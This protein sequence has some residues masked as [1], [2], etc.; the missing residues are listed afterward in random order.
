MP[1]LIH[2]TILLLT[3]GGLNLRAQDVAPW[4]GT[5][6]RVP[7]LEEYQRNGA[8]FPRSNE[9]LFV[10]LKVH[11]VGRDDGEGYANVDD[12]L[13]ALCIL[14]EDFAQVN[15]EFYLVGGFNFINNTSYYRHN[16]SV[17]RVMMSKNNAPNAIN[18]YVVDDPNGVAG[19]SNYQQ[20]IALSRVEMATDERVWA[21]EI[22]H[23]LSLPHTFLG[24]ENYSHDYAKPAPAQVN[25]VTVEKANGS[26]CKDAGDGFC[27][28]PADY[29][30]DRWTCN[31]DGKSPR[32]QFDPDSTQLRSDGTL[33]MS[34]ANSECQSRFS[35]EQIGAMRANLNS[36]R[37]N[38]IS[39]QPAVDP[40][41]LSDVAPVLLSPRNRETLPFSNQLALTWEA[42]PEAEFY[43]VQ[44]SITPL[45]TLMI[46][47]FIT[48]DPALFATSV[49]L[50]ANR[51]YYWRV[52]GLSRQHYCRGSWSD[53]FQFR[54]GTLTATQDPELDAGVTVFPNP[55]H[56]GEL[57]LRVGQQEA[58]QALQWQL[59]DQMG[60]MVRRGEER[61]GGLTERRVDVR[62]LP[63]GLYYLRL[64]IADRQLTRKIIIGD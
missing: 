25:S 52:R 35:G 37:R 23:Y 51:P 14:N 53:A 7:W 19:Y 56:T 42:V 9:T 63:T 8:V 33:I 38:L 60:R 13:E 46:D 59:I 6:E 47:Q 54:T 22:G 64:Q 30:S 21:H 40:T 36:E 31:S 5:N 57:V 61:L 24:W 3:V 55:V 15:V 28:T 1:N 39:N 43:L 20:G 49:H 41:P 12:V 11:I 27:D 44:V 34:Y 58:G 32:L 26:N 4:C 62:Q 18:C 29:L 17:G 2:L 45:F 50:S 48:T 10:P 16:Y